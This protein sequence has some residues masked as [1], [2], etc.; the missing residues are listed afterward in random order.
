MPSSSTPAPCP[1]AAPP[2]RCSCSVSPLADPLRSARR[3]AFLL[4]RD[5]IGG[6]ITEIIGDGPS[7][8]RRAARGRADG[9][10]GASGR[11]RAC[12]SWSPPSAPT[13]ACSPATSIAGWRPA[14][15]PPITAS[16]LVEWFVIGPHG[17]DCPRDLLG[18]PE[19]WSFSCAAATLRRGQPQARRRAAGAPARGS[20]SAPR[21]A[22]PSRRSTPRARR[23]GR[24]GSHAAECP[25][26]AA[27]SCSSSRLSS[28]TRWLHMRPVQMPARFVDQHGHRAIRSHHEHSGG[29]TARPRGSTWPAPSH[30]AAAR[31]SPRPATA[32]RTVAT[33]PPRT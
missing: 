30:R 8:G 14:T 12:R 24:R 5:G 18:E 15:S 13:P 23:S 6:V 10:C 2:T 11:T 20:A 16:T 31:A 7:P 29:R 4:D 26:A 33:T 32:N 27:N 9:H 19:R 21:R 3:Y 25:R 22:P 28:L 1:C 17:V